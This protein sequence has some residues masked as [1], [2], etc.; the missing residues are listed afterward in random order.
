MAII[1]YV[2]DRN[3][4]LIGQLFDVVG[5][6]CSHKLNDVSTGELTVSN[7]NLADALLILKENNRIK[8]M[9]AVQGTEKLLMEGY[10]RGIE[11]TLKNTVIK[12]EDMISFL[13][14]KI[15]FTQMNY[16]WPINALLQ[17]ILNQI[18]TKENTWLVLVSDVTAT[19]TKQY[20]KGESF[21]NVLKDLR[22]NAYEYTVRW[23]TLYF[24]HTIGINRSISSNDY[25][26]LVW[27]LNSP[28]D[29][30]IRDAKLIM[31]IKQMCNSCIGKDG[32]A[33]GY[34]ENIASIQ[35][36]WRIERTFTNS[37]NI[38]QAT[39]NYVNERKDSIKEFEISPN[40]P[41][42]YLCDVGDIVRVYINSW[43]DLMFYDGAMKVIEKSYTAWEL[44]KVTFK[45]GKN[46]I[47]T[48]DLAEKL[49]DV[50]RR[51]GKLEL[52]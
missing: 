25:V 12:I 50:N 2:Y 32:N 16:T 45:L 10:M 35:E 44:P 5:F 51:L 30:T 43:N 40:I 8:V 33:Y 36:F 28:F 29:R 48:I 47:K 6:E 9:E 46:K 14:D 17:Q 22:Q 4:T 15:L 34:A 21:A 11:A 52:Q 38:Q 24:M 42:F 41:N 7:R 3:D 31:D 49:R 27:D 23:N 26:E 37:G 39:Q 13:D 20:A 1:G 19:I 18:N